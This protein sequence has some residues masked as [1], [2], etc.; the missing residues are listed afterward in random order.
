MITF[1]EYITRE[2]LIEEGYNFSDN[3]IKAIVEA[4]FLDRVKKFGRNAAL[5]G[6]IGT[7]AL[8]GVG[9]S[10]G[11]QKLE[12]PTANY[13]QQQRVDQVK[14]NMASAMKGKVQGQHHMK[15]HMKKKMK[16]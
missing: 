5:A 4:G 3:E 16:K 10:P 11:A 13:L 12:K 7:A 1:E 9:A 8:A 6:A 2:I 15:K 14:S